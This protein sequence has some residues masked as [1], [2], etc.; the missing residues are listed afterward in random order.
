MKLEINEEGKWVTPNGTTARAISINLQFL[1]G[2]DFTMQ[3]DYSKTVVVG[4]GEADI[5]THNRAMKEENCKGS[6][7]RGVVTAEEVQTAFETFY[8][9]IFDSVNE[10][11]FPTPPTVVEE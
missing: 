4:D 7:D 3:P 9:V 2:S 5:T 11:M 8:K 10:D 6:I 1:G